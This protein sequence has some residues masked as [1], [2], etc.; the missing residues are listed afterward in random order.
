MCLLNEQANKLINRH[1]GKEKPWCCHP[2]SPSLAWTLRSSRWKLFSLQNTRAP[3]PASC[4]PGVSSPVT[5]LLTHPWAPGLGWHYLHFSGMFPWCIT[6]LQSAK[7]AFLLH[8]RVSVPQTFL[9]TS[10]TLP[11][12]LPQHSMSPAHTHLSRVLCDSYLS[13]G[14]S[15]WPCVPRRQGTKS[16]PQAQPLACGRRHPCLLRGLVITARIGSKELSKG[17]KLAQRYA[18]WQQSRGQLPD[19]WTPCS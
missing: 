7:E 19:P 5:E 1:T 2:L 13:L 14:P 9:V 15:T 11:A 10:L 18:L 17:N 3:V 4:C 8:R 16:H 6:I 12:L